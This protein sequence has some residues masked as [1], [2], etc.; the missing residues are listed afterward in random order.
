MIT[1]NKKRYFPWQYIAA[2]RTKNKQVWNLKPLFKIPTKSETVDSY[3]FSL[4][5][6]DTREREPV[7]SSPV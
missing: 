4:F 2:N 1:P 7:I 5:A 3:F 6:S